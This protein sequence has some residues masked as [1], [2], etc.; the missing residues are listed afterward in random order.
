MSWI[1]PIADV[2]ALLTPGERKRLL[3]LTLATF[4]QSLVSA[5]VVA[6]VV[7]F[8]ALV[9]NPMRI[10]DH[11]ILRAAYEG[12]GCEE[13][14]DL[15]LF[16]GGALFFF[17][18][19]G[20]ALSAGNNWLMQRFVYRKQQ[21]LAS[22]LLSHYLRQPYAF[23]LQR[24]SSELAQNILTEVGTAVRGSLAPFTML[25]IRASTTLVLLGLLLYVHPVMT[26]VVISLVGFA[27]GV[28]FLRVRR[29]Q[30][31]LGKDRLEAEGQRHRIAV[32]SL[33]GIKDV[34][35]LGR[36]EAFL[37]RFS[38]HAELHAETLC[39]SSL[40]GAIP[41]YLLESLAFGS[42]LGIVLYLLLERGDVVQ[43]LPTLGL[44]AFAS[45][46]IIPSIQA[47]FQAT[48]QLRFTAPAVN[49]LRE[50]LR[51]PAPAAADATAPPLP[52]EEAVRLEDVAFTYPGAPTPSLTGLSLQIPRGACV[53][54][55]GASGAGKTTVVDLLLGLHSPTSGRVV[56]DG[57]PLTPE[58]GSRWRRSVGYVPQQVYLSD[59]SI[60]QNIAFGIPLSHIDMSAVER[61]ARIAHLHEFVSKLPEGYG[62]VIGSRGVRLSG[63]QRQR[64]GIA[65]A[66]YHDPSLIILDE[67]TNALDGVT[68]GVVME[69][70]GEL[71]RIK[72]LVIIAHRLSSVRDCDVIYLLES[73]RLLD[74]GA[75]DEM[76]DRS[77]VFR[78]MAGL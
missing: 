31:Q 12:L 25:I 14:R 72:T 19:I 67:A 49:R 44:F 9:A 42:V 24:N 28:I 63:G 7:P 77:Q 74:S 3:A 21:A 29:L 2:V 16:A 15:L 43:A 54:L 47:I 27:Y 70:I 40:V 17:L 4:L 76:L 18:L 71:A 66:L 75:W 22:E 60:S 32:E 23:F 62:T 8:L 11:D 68:E 30:R 58:L 69:A 53:G 55:V 46:R 13:P 65:R 26:I 37:A 6:S 61:S 51:L 35:A 78:A 41:R 5:G 56:V 64:I 36:E 48:N 20:N 73:G 39:R 1:G 50:E 59:E 10:F 38:H 34:K 45:F 52:L 57:V 33:E